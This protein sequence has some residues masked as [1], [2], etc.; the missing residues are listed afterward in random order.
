[1]SRVSHEPKP[2][3]IRPVAVRCDVTPLGVTLYIILLAGVQTA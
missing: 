2:E 1:M 3:L